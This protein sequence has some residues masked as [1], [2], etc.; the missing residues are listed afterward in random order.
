M[1]EEFKAVEQT[2]YHDSIFGYYVEIPPPPP[3]PIPPTWVRRT[4]K[5]FRGR[6]PYGAVSEVR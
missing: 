2:K 3:P 4:L 6:I 1:T 5:G